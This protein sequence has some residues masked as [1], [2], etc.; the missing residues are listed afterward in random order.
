LT[1]YCVI[2]STNDSKLPPTLK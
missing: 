2:S 1:F